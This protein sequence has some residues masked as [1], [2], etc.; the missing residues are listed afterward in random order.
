MEAKLETKITRLKESVKAEK[1]SAKEV[2]E[3]WD[4]NAKKTSRTIKN[5]LQSSFEMYD[6]KVKELLDL[7]VECRGADE[8]T[9]ERHSTMVAEMEAI[10]RE[11]K[12]VCNELEDIAA[13]VGSVSVG[14]KT[15]DDIIVKL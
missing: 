2:L 9:E 13:S 3:S 7:K 5:E 11:V 8:E 4:E 14:S 12:A 10:M 15:V 1:D 6:N